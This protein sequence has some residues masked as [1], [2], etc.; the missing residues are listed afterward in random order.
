MQ[1]RYSGTLERHG[2]A[3]NRIWTLVAEHPSLNHDDNGNRVSVDLIILKPSEHDLKV[4]ATL[5]C[6]S[7]LIHSF[8]GGVARRG[9]PPP[10]HLYSVYG[11][12]RGDAIHTSAW[13]IHTL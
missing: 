6:I 10:S 4:L 11:A 2:F 8:Y 7:A 9:D 12:R 5:V 13:R 3:R 1:P